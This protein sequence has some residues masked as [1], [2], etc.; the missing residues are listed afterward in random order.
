[1]PLALDA[2]DTRLFTTRRDV[3][4]RLCLPACQERQGTALPFVTRP[5]E[6][7]RLLRSAACVS[8]PLAPLLPSRAALARSPEQRF[9]SHAPRVGVL[10]TGARIGAPVARPRL[11][12]LEARHSRAAVTPVALLLLPADA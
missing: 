6:L 4:A 2:D 5:P 9:C 8:T 12:A 1:M 7:V 10:R 3:S 11:A